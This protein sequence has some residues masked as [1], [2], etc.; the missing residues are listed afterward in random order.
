[1]ER[2]DE[3]MSTEKHLILLEADEGAGIEEILTKHKIKILEN[4]LITS[5]TFNMVDQ[6]FA[7]ELRQD[8]LLHY[9]WSQKPDKEKNPMHLEITDETY[10]TDE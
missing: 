7:N 4:E 1:M 10:N 6:F 9:D 8:F 5:R 2:Y 3:Q